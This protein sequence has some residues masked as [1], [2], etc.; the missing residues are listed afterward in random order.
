MNRP[1]TL[2]NHMRPFW[3]V[4]A[5]L[6][7]VVVTSGCTSVDMTNEEVTEWIHENCH[8][9]VWRNHYP[10]PEEGHKG[11]WIIQVP[12]DQIESKCGEGAAACAY[13]KAGLGMGRM[14]LPKEDPLRYACHEQGHINGTLRCRP[15][16]ARGVG[17]AGTSCGWHYT[18]KPEDLEPTWRLR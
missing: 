9:W 6:L 16:D 4:V 13:S 2:N 8:K 10:I 11:A 12:R 1:Y 7:L 18:V 15:H 17:M 3:A 5:V 14:Y